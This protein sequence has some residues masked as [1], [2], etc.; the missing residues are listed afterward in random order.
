MIPCGA[1]FKPSTTP[2]ES[3][4]GLYFD[5]IGHLFLS[6]PLERCKLFESQTNSSTMETG[7]VISV[8]IVNYCTKIHNATWYSLND[9]R[10]FT[11]YIRSKVKYVE[12][13][14]HIQGVSQKT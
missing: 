8:K 2:I 7:K 10:A 1:E 9:C 5:K 6:Y 14:R 12:K 11:P 3:H 4:T 13:L